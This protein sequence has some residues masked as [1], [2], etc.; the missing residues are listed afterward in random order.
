LTLNATEK[1][2]GFE[3]P[4]KNFKFINN[5]SLSLELNN[6]FGFLKNSFADYNI[7]DIKEEV[8]LQNINYE[9]SLYND[10]S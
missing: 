10:L 3:Y 6:S 1:E 8:L 7:K 4:F 2:I 9:M 5:N